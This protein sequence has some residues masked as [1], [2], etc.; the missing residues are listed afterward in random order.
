MHRRTPGT[1]TCEPPARP[2]IF[3]EG[4]SRQVSPVKVYQA[5][6][7]RGIPQGPDE[8]DRHT[9]VLMRNPAGTLIDLWEFERGS[10]KAVVKVAGWF[11]SNGREVVLDRVLAV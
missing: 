6:A 4:V 2:T 5:S 11:S 7:S 1:I 8:L 10:E 9:C 3:P